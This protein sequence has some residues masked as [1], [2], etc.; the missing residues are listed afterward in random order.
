MSDFDLDQIRTTLAE[1]L[2][3]LPT[4]STYDD[5]V[6]IE[7]KTKQLQ[8][9]LKEMEDKLVKLSATTKNT[10]AQLEEKALLR[11]KFGKSNALLASIS[12]IYERN[13]W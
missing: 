2:E 4:A 7:A 8:A 3:Q 1:L 5:R 6:K 11:D 13:S 10:N 12:S 9:A